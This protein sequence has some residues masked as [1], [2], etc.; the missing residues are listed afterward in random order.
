MP[1]PKKI[2]FEALCFSNFRHVFNPDNYVRKTTSIKRLK[3]EK[4]LLLFHVIFNNGKTPLV[5]LIS[6]QWS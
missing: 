6:T 3:N 1:P 4:V 5:N 2:Q